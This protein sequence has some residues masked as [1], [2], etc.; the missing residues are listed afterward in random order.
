ME[1]WDIKKPYKLLYSIKKAG[2]RTKHLVSSHVSVDALKRK[3][4]RIRLDAFKKRY[5]HVTYR[6]TYYDGISKSFSIHVG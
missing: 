6:A 4:R 5:N 1:S 3:V 2:C